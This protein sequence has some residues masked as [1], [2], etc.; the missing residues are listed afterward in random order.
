MHSRSLFALALMLLPL[1]A[2]AQGLY[3]THPT[4]RPVR[5][6]IVHLYVPNGQDMNQQENVQFDSTGRPQSITK[7][8]FGGE[9]HYLIAPEQNLRAVVDADGDTLEV[10]RP[11]SS[12]YYAYRKPHR[13]SAAKVYYYKDG[14]VNYYRLLRYN[15]HGD[16]ATSR[17]YSPDDLLE[18]KAKYRYRYDS[19][20]NW[21]ERRYVLN[22]KIRYTHTRAIHYW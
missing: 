15:R 16:V 3:A 1:A 4:A 10:H 11:G 2:W 12:T 7:W 14:A 22:G 6:M 9:V 18:E 21:V 20:G 5:A 8:G 19:E 13:R 17:R